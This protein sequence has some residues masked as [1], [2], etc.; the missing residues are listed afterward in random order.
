MPSFVG[1]DG[2]LFLPS[3]E[4]PEDWKYIPARQNIRAGSNTPISSAQNIQVDSNIAISSATFPSRAQ[5]L[6][7]SYY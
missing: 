7:S 3:T 5:H 1:I 6:D 2:K 4:H